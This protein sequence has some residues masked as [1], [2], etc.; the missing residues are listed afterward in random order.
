[1]MN[2]VKSNR[3]GAII[4]VHEQKEITLRNMVSSLEA[5]MKNMKKRLEKLKQP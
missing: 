3:L 5:K 1:M 2:L 4:V